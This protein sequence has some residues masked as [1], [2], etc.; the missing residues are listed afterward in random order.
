MLKTVLDFNLYVD[1]TTND[2]IYIDTMFDDK[3]QFPIED[4]GLVLS[5]N[6]IYPEIRTL[7]KREIRMLVLYTNA[8]IVFDVSVTSDDCSIITREIIEP[9]P[10]GNSLRTTYILL[11]W[12]IGKLPKKIKITKLKNYTR[13]GDEV[14]YTEH[15][16]LELNSRDLTLD[17]TRI[18]LMKQDVYIVSEIVDGKCIFL[19]DDN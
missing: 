18:P 1:K 17:S 13:T 2:L 12:M 3:I 9:T 19:G 6:F 5:E 14:D 8:D 10:L 16:K 11:S 7:S 4:L 15:V